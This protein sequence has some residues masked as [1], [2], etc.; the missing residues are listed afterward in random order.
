MYFDLI[1]VINS[2][3]S[4]NV[5]S[6]I[7]FHITV[8]F[9]DKYLIK[10]VFVFQQKIVCLSKT[11]H[12]NIFSMKMYLFMLNITSFYSSK[13]YNFKIK[14]F[15]V[16]CFQRILS[17]RHQL[18]STDTGHRNASQLA[19]NQHGNYNPYFLILRI[20]VLG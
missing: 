7:C 8:L 2:N 5:F 3:H 18:P 14:Q 17:G 11:F 16:N 6:D 9:T 10:T 4:K 13:N 1:S 20:F 19:G 12:Q 15:I